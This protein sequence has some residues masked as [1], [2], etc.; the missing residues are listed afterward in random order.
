M[1]FEFFLYLHFLNELNELQCNNTVVIKSTVEV[2][3]TSK[4][5]EKYQN[6]KFVFNP[7]FLTEVNFIE[8]FKNQNRI[9]LGSNNTESAAR[10]VELY[11]KIYNKKD[12]VRIETTSSTNAEMV[13]Y[14]TNTFLAVKVSF[15]NEIAELSNVVGADYDESIRLASLDKRLG[16]SHWQ[17]PGPDGKNGFGGSCFPKDINSLLYLFESNQLNSYILNA[18]WERNISVDRPEKDWNDLKGRAVSKE[19]K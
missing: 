10:V 1:D 19:E 9:I 4:F 7:E 8:D 2:G 3:T 11:S 5:S 14:I 17:V 15:A 16:N 6:L 18:A 13:K 12:K